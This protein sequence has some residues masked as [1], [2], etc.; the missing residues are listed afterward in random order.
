LNDGDRLG[1]ADHEFV[2]HFRRNDHD[3]SKLG[4]GRSDPA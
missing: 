1:I 4:Q 2:L 3:S